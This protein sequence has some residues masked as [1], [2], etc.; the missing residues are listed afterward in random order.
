MEDGYAGPDRRHADRRL[1][2]ERR[3]RPSVA[4]APGR[5]LAPTRA[6]QHLQFLVRYLFAVLGMAYFAM[7]EPENWTWLREGLL[8]F[9]FF[10][11]VTL[12]VV[13]HLQVARQPYSMFRFRLAMWT[14]L[15]AASIC[16]LNDPYSVPVTTMAY[17]VV[18]LGNGTRYGMACFR[19]AVVG[20]FLLAVASLSVRYSF[21]APA[22][23]PPELFLYVLG[24]FTLLYSYI[25][26]SRVDAS[27]RSLELNSRIDPLT[28]LYNRGALLEAAERLLDRVAHRGGRLVVMFADLDKFKA[29]NDT[30]GHAAGDRVLREVGRILRKSVR[31]TDIAAR[32]GG[33][34]FVL[35]LPETRLEQAEWVARRIQSAMARWARDNGL[36]VSMTIGLGEAPAHG[37]DLDTL[38]HRVDQALYASKSEKGTGGICAASTT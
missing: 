1:G 34:E 38:L 8:I 9:V 35:L 26:M 10:A 37:S 5:W 15:A 33:D 23:S 12:H 28:G 27:R 3:G 11:Y 21:T 6:E 17:I 31:E 36:N 18:V 14:D 13:L 30:Q 25:L 7:A 20:T 24:S 32:Y 2:G 16:V 22:L 29:I 19:E 4:S